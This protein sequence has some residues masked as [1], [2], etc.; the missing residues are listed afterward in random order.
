MGRKVCGGTSETSAARRMTQGQYAEDD[1]NR[2][3]DGS[4]WTR[5]VVRTLH[6]RGED[7]GWAQRARGRGAGRRG[8]ILGK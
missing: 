1:L 2:F 3:P 4:R 7:D 8:V 6:G 5:D